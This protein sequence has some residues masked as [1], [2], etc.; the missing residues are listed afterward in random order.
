M[1]IFHE[2][3]SKEVNIIYDKNTCHH[4]CEFRY[5]GVKRKKRI[6]LLA[7]ALLQDDYMQ[8]DFQL[9]FSLRNRAPSSRRTAKHMAKDGSSPSCTQGRSGV[10]NH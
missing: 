2:R 7:S 9:L 6:W 1:R 10:C 8:S 3:R 5:S 4:Q